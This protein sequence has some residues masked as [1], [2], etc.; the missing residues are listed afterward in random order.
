MKMKNLIAFASVA[1]ALT[2]CSHDE[3]FTPSWQNDP[4]AMK[5][6]AT[7]GSGIFSRSNP[8][9]DETQQKAFNDGDE[10]SIAAGTQNAVVYKLT[11]GTW[12]P[13]AGYLKWE[14]N[15]MAITA[16]YPVTDE[17][18]AQAFTLPTEQDTDTKIAAADYMTYS[19]SKGKPTT[20][21]E[22]SIEMVRKMARVIVKIAGFNNQ[23][24]T[25]PTVTDVKIQSGAASYTAGSAAGAVTKVTP[26]AQNL[27]EGTAPTTYIALV[28]PTTAKS[29]ES[30]ITMTVAGTE[31][32]VKGIPAMEA[33]KSY[34]YNLTIGKDAL[35]MGTVTVTPWENGTIE[36]GQVTQ[37]LTLTTTGTLTDAMLTEALGNG[38][39]LLIEGSMSSD[40]FATLRDWAIANKDEHPLTTLDLSGV[41]GLTALPDNA[42]CKVE[43]SAE[44]PVTTSVETLAS[45]KLPASVTMIGNHTFRGCTALKDIDLSRI[46]AIGEYGFSGCT[47]L[48]VIDAPQLVL[49]KKHVFYG[50]G[51]VSGINLPLSTGVENVDTDIAA[52]GGITMQSGG[53][54]NLP[55]CT[56]VGKYMFEGLKATTATLRMTAADTIE[57][58]NEAFGNITLSWSKFVLVLNQDKKTGGS[59]RPTV[60]DGNGW[61]YFAA[62]VVIPWTSITYVDNNG[63]VVQ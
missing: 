23:Y 8:L 13:E 10:I 16:Y 37:I 53:T 56:K 4:T 62:G 11:A 12:I 18:S 19:N 22:L 24:G 3:D 41:T 5:V 25:T 54:I 20:G 39:T 55:L 9:G 14:T 40:H 26:Y 51:T 6:N 52:L 63:N 28:I 15:P 36:G 48:G 61:G 38:S 1:V 49:L 27:N 47:S 7:V 30:F 44:S 29:T 42:F 2:A 46:T 33:G 34:T 31:L 45:I 58:N 17:T 21:G 50:C 60:W 35:T 59:G 57:M 43:G 32:T